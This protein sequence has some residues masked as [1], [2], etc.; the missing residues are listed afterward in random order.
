MRVLQMRLEG[1]T[2]GATLDAAA[3]AAVRYLRNDARTAVRLHAVSA[4]HAHVQVGT[5]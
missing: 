4:V 3:G 5:T 1:A 2:S